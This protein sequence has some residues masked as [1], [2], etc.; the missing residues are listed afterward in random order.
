MGLQIPLY[1]ESI[2]TTCGNTSLENVCRSPVVKMSLN[3]KDTKEKWLRSSKFSWCCIII[4]IYMGVP[5]PDP[6]ENFKLDPIVYLAISESSD[7]NISS[8]HCPFM[9]IEY[10]NMRWLKNWVLIF[11]WRSFYFKTFE[12]N[13]KKNPIQSSFYVTFWQLHC[14]EDFNLDFVA[15]SQIPWSH[16]MATTDQRWTVIW[17]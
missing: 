17:K 7:N 11:F 10:Q 6:L 3:L 9:I 12:N 5:H 15:L 13:N 8:N 2:S 4:I 1:N 14:H 16:L